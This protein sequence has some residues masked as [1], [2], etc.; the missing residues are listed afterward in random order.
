MLRVVKAPRVGGKG[1]VVD[2][3]ASRVV[4]MARRDGE[5]KKLESAS[6]PSCQRCVSSSEHQ[7]R[8][9]GRERTFNE[10]KAQPPLAELASLE[11][12]VIRVS[13]CL[14]TGGS[15]PSSM[16]STG[17]ST[18]ARV[19]E[20]NLCAGRSLWQGVEGHGHNAEAAGRQV[21][22]ELEE[23]ASRQGHRSRKRARRKAS[24]L[25]REGGPRS[26][27]VCLEREVRDRR[28][29]PRSGGLSTKLGEG[30]RRA[31]SE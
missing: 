9:K 15:L 8:A 2:A 1:V 20:S 18:R 6:G 30:R 31:E 29:G 27:E 10:S 3:R 22:A 23:N 25:Y 7:G 16:S 28:T 12:N 5:G 4:V 24:E 14:E 21:E 13:K 19:D 11:Q 17:G 26:G